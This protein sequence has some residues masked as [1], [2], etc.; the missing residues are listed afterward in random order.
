MTDK[1][2]Y[3]AKSI[4]VLEGLEA[5]RKRPGMYIGNTEKEGLHHLI[6]EI[7]DNSLDEAMNGYATVVEVTMKRDG[8]ILVED[9]GRGIPTGK[10]KSGKS[11]LE[12]VFT[13][14]HAGGKFD[15]DNYKTSG[16]LHGVGASVVNALSEKMVVDVTRD[17]FLWRM[18]FSKG[19]RKGTLKKV[20]KSRGTGTVIHFFPDPEIFPSIAFDSELIH[21]RLKQSSFLHSGTKI[22]F[23]NEE[24]DD[25]FEWQ[26]EDGL[27]DF[28]KDIV[29]TKTA[30]IIH[31]EPFTV[32]GIVE[33]G[34]FD[35]S[36]AWTDGTDT[37]AKSYVN[38]VPTGS[39]GTHQLAL[40]ASL[41]RATKTY[42]EM[43]NKMPKRGGAFTGEDVR[44]GIVSILSLFI[45]E[46]QFQGQTKDKL[47]N[48]EIKSKL[49]S[50][51]ASD[52]EK[53]MV[54]NSKEGKKILDRIL[55][56]MRSRLASRAIKE[57]Y[58]STKKLNA[59]LPGKLSD[60][61]STGTPASELFL[62]EGDSAG[63]SAK[64]GRDPNYQA[65]LPLR[66]KILNAI[67]ATTSSV[68]KNEEI[69]NITNA[70]DCGWG[71][72]CDPSKSRYGKI[73]FLA[74]ADVDGQHITCLLLAFFAKYMHKMIEAGRVFIACPPLY[75]VVSGKLGTTHYAATDE[76]KDEYLEKLKTKDYTL[77]RFKGLGEM[78][79]KTLWETTMS[80]ENRKLLRVKSEDREVAMQH[81]VD[82]LG[83][84]PSLRREMVN[85]DEAIEK[86]KIISGSEFWQDTEGNPYFEERRKMWY[87]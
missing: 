57:S 20:K 29:S 82:L 83:K 27:L 14:L 78:P 66:G 61:V 7:T 5:V 80:P 30:D 33:G 50:S 64:Q 12:V 65:I 73:I 72:N 62:V 74:D 8:S 81:L 70:I 23:V 46:P 59:I 86:L 22:V 1:K 6:W 48:P 36:L 85:D 47:N 16:G 44:E 39:G 25:R 77:T 31:N 55:L 19:K 71:E 52:L 34:R 13:T 38:G 9:N 41:L 53:W 51:I 87:E 42:A 28:L 2:D 56:S 76:D 75:K 45:S 79:P 17:G 63:G 3:S 24:L 26:H 67:Q 35:L 68:T 40:D 21:D 37:T 11:A 54:H 69:Q 18:I 15:S 58:R 84:N 43:T 32:S 49:T 4:K 60:C 10:H